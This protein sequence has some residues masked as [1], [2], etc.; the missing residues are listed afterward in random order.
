M[1]CPNPKCPAE[2]PVDDKFCPE[3]GTRTPESPKAP[4]GQGLQIGEK[5]MVTGEV[6]GGDKIDVKTHGGDAHIHHHTDQTKEVR[7]CSVCG[8]EK[9]RVGFHNCPTCHQPACEECFDTSQNKCSRCSLQATSEVRDQFRKTVEEV[10]AD[11]R[12]D[13]E[14]IQRLNTEATRLGLSDEEARQIRLEIENRQSLQIDQMST[15][16]NIKLT[17]AG[18]HLME[19]FNPGEALSKLEPLYANYGQTNKEVRRL[20]LL[21]LLEEDTE[22][23]LE[24]ANAYEFD[25]RDVYMVRIEA[26]SRLDRDSECERVLKKAKGAFPGDIQVEAAEAE[27]LLVDYWQDENKDSVLLEAAE[28]ILS[29]LKDD[30]DDLYVSSVR[31]YLRYLKGDEDSLEQEK[32]RLVE[33]G[34]SPFY[35]LRRLK[36]LTPAEEEVTPVEEE[37]T[38]VEEEV[39]PVEEEV[40]PVEEEVA[41]VEVE[42]WKIDENAEG[43]NIHLSDYN[44]KYNKNAE[45]VVDALIDI[46]EALGEAGEHLIYYDELRDTDLDVV[47]ENKYTLQS[48]LEDVPLPLCVLSNAPI[49]IIEK[50]R[51]VLTKARAKVE[52]ISTHDGI[53]VKIKNAKELDCLN[54]SDISDELRVHEVRINNFVR[55]QDNNILLKGVNEKFAKRIKAIIDKTKGSIKAKVVLRDCNGNK[56]H[57]EVKETQ[58]AGPGKGNG[59]SGIEEDEE[60]VQQCIEVIRVEQRASVSLIQRRLSLDYTRAA[61]IMDELEGRGLV[62]PTR[63]TEPREILFEAAGGNVEIHQGNCQ[64]AKSGAPADSPPVIKQAQPVLA[65]VIAHG[66]AHVPHHKNIDETKS[67]AKEL[68]SKINILEG[69]RDAINKKIKPFF[70]TFIISLILKPLGLL[71]LLAGINFVISAEPEATASSETLVLVQ[72]FVALVGLLII[73]YMFIRDLYHLTIGKLIRK[74]ELRKID[75]E[76]SKLK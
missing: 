13:P 11:G 68:E 33:S 38:P 5:A 72:G 23:A 2:V 46:K 49:D 3:C 18:K 40:T 62:G 43:F 19:E 37:V 4:S 24:I 47:K 26:L 8:L 1:K 14:E 59:G 21:A 28:G 61:R 27:I 16:E 41:P 6:V 75:E 76:L 57:S 67:E 48:S 65:P 32:D 51:A 12:V 69:K 10:Y 64:P 31:A 53:D 74:G 9:E 55:S 15:R 7:E 20:Y 17:S 66:D 56:I 42:T 71:I 58:T 22:K 25:D 45:F 29:N 50:A 44:K 73:I 63:G 54:Y 36:A 35:V 52:T 34:L 39:T 30:G 70:T 60:I